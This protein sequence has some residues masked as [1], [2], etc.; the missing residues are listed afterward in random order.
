M[1]SGGTRSKSKIA[2][3]GKTESERFAAIQQEAASS[4]APP[5]APS[6]SNLPEEFPRTEPTSDPTDQHEPDSEAHDDD[7]AEDDDPSD[8][9]SPSLIVKMSGVEATKVPKGLAEHQRLKGPENYPQW[10][11]AMQ[12][13]FYSYNC[14]KVM[15][16]AFSPATTN[17]SE[18]K[19]GKSH[20]TSTSTSLP[21]KLDL[22]DRSERMVQLINAHSLILSSISEKAQSYCQGLNDPI[23]AWR[24][25]EAW[26]QGTGPVQRQVSQ[27]ELNAL[28]SGDFKTADEFVNKFESLRLRLK[29][30]GRDYSDDYWIDQFICSAEDQY[31]S[32]ASDH[33]RALRFNPDQITL[34]AVQTDLIDEAKNK[35]KPPRSGELTAYASNKKGKKG[36]EEKKGKGKKKYKPGECPH[37]N[38]KP[39]D[40]W[41]DHP[42]KRPKRDS[43][44]NPKSTE[45]RQKNSEN[46]DVSVFTQEVSYF[47]DDS[48]NVEAEERGPTEEAYSVGQDQKSPCWKGDSG[49][50]CHIGHT[51]EDFVSLDYSKSLSPIRTGS[52]L[53]KPTA[54]GIIRKSVRNTKGEITRMALQDVYYVP[55]FPINIFSF[56]KF[57]KKGGR[58]NGFDLVD[59]SGRVTGSFDSSFN[60]Q[61]VD[62][63]PEETL[64]TEDKHI[65]YPLWHMRLGHIGREAIKQTAKVTEGMWSKQEDL[66]PADTICEPCDEGKNLRYTPKPGRAIPESAGEEWHL[67]SVHIQY[68]GGQEE[69]WAI[70]LTEAKYGYRVTYTFEEKGQAN[71]ALI[72]HVRRAKR[73]WKVPIKRIVMD[74]GSELYG[75]QNGEFDQL[76]KDEGIEVIKSAPYTPEH[77]GVAERANRIIIEKTR[78]WMLACMADPRLWPWF[79]TTAVEYTNFLCVTKGTTTG[80]TRVE[81]FLEENVPGKDHSVDLTYLR[82][83]GSKVKVHIPKERRE[84]ADKFGPRAEDGILLGWRGKSIYVVYLPDRPGHFT[85]KIVTTSNLIFYEQVG[86]KVLETSVSDSTV[87]TTSDSITVRSLPPNARKVRRGQ[88]DQLESLVAECFQISELAEIEPIT[89][90][91]AL[92]GPNREE[93]LNSFYD[94]MRNM[95]RNKVFRAMDRTSG[96]RAVTPRLVFRNKFNKEGTVEKRK[97]RIVVSRCWVT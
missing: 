10:T 42:E 21:T 67:D 58:I 30:L 54:I 82:T 19:S 57:Y 78:T 66:T 46:S 37:T 52:G 40:C 75:P 61:V 36:K 34:M 47:A 56:Q 45:S 72:N 17:E 49:S 71:Q 25:L 35:V 97:V 86:K 31:P 60:L 16:P 15:T 14:Y 80:K 28:K 12:M 95:L 1:S 83:P 64:L 6:S 2:S 59:P 11:A 53:I 3:E 65:D 38:H 51:K 79:W 88:R 55:T 43:H 85:Q 5:T 81:A 50:T 26:C 91:E 39:E 23:A 44:S 7:E 62:E 41:V 63:T 9:S 29:T 76:V 69:F 94:E 22:N 33:R 87:E 20:S 96:R 13:A 77:N 89:L 90:E 32:W 48:E 92:S 93:W 27:R 4:S 74:G 18:T 70:I 8:P 68:P 24:K 73:Q 84:N